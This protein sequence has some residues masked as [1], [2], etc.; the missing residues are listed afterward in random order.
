MIEALGLP[1]KEEKQFVLDDRATNRAAEHVPAEFVFWDRF[2]WPQEPVL[3]LVGVQLIVAKEFPQGAVERI[4]PRPDRCVDNAAL[5]VAE[6]GGC[7]LGDEIEFLNRIRRWRI[8]HE[9]IRDLV[10]VYAI[11]NEIIGLL[12]VPVDVRASAVCRVVT[13]VKAVRGRCNGPRCQ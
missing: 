7:V 5:I 3:P 4:R 11:E 8:A 13:V 9:V 6:L 12:A 10:V 1:I 2:A